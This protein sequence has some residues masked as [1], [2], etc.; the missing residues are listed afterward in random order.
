LTASI[1]PDI[2]AML[3]ERTKNICRSRLIEALVANWLAVVIPDHVGVAQVKYQNSTGQ[4]SPPVQAE[5][6]L[7]S[8][9]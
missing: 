6:G 7:G 4:V 9:P 8:P 5:G 2:Y 3:A 1:D